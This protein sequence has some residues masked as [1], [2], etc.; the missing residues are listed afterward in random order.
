MVI[1][2]KKYLT[3]HK[4]SK[5]P[6]QLQL[7]FLKRL[8]RL[9]ME[10][11]PMIDA[12][13]ILKWDNQMID[14]SNE[15]IRSLKEGDTLDEAL[16]KVNFHPTIT[17]YLFF[18][19]ENGEIQANIEKCVEMYE[20]RLN[21]IKKFSEIARYP[22]ILLFVFSILL[23]FIK[24]SVLPSF[25]ELF[26]SSTEASQSILLFIK[27]IEYGVIIIII[28]FL[29]S[30]ILSI[31]WYFN[32]R[33]LSIKKQ[34]K[35]YRKIPIYRR[36][37]VLQVSFQFSMH[38]STMLRS[39]MP[40]KEILLSMAQQDKQP[41]IAYYSTLM[42]N[43]LSHGLSITSLLLDS[44]FLDKRLAS[45]FRKNTDMES[46]EKDLLVYSDLLTEELQMKI[47]K[48]MTLIQPVIFICLGCFVVFI[49]LTLMLPMYQLIKT[50]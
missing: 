24:Q 31:L 20:S 36:F 41:I 37:L 10:G 50:I 1:F 25:A 38:L 40:L 42:T 7:R 8:S 3:L 26:Q 32:K 21:Y 39:G 9:L 35:L 46:L 43:D 27:I 6:E 30:V 16:E 47:T 29:I 18:V 5:L 33:K 2:L 11:Y 15:I 49:Y 28:L 13:E 23:Y 48:I 14:L 4:K 34:I 45:I 12:L 19:R 44:D 17:D 22:L